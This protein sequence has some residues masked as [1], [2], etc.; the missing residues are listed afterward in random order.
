GLVVL[1]G[2]VL[3]DP[4][5]AAVVRPAPG[6]PVCSVLGYL[7]HND[8][9]ERGC[10]RRLGIFPDEGHGFPFVQAPVDEAVDPLGGEG[11]P[12]GTV[13]APHGVT[14]ELG[15]FPGACEMKRQVAGTPRGL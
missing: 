9:V 4:Y 1:S 10:D 8:D 2:I 5:R 7:R 14:D 12:V 15:D 11:S 3:V 13:R 6:V